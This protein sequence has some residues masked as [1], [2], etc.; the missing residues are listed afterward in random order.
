[1]DVILYRMCTVCHR[2]LTIMF[3]DDTG[4]Y[5]GG[6]FFGDMEA[7]DGK[8]IEDWQCDYCASGYLHEN[9]NN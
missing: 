3:D 8:M 9:A 4:E 1:M 5:T 2:P 7:N 6:Q